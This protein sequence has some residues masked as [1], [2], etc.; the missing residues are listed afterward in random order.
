MFDG[1]LSLDRADAVPLAE[2]IYR[3]VRDAVRAGRAPGDRRLPSSR[4]LARGLGVSRNTVNAA[5]E[6]LRGEGLIVSRPGA[7]PV[8]AVPEAFSAPMAG[9]AAAVRLS[10]QG[11]ALARNRHEADYVARGG[12]LRPGH[13]DPALFPRDEWAW[14]MRRA[15]RTLS[16]DGLLY[17]HVQGLPELR[18]VLAEAL[19]ARRGLPVM[20]EQVHV[21]PTVQSALAMLG[22]CL[23]DEGET[24]WIE[25]PGY[26]GARAALGHG[27]LVPLPVDGEGADASRLTGV[28]K[29]V[30]VT[31]SHQYPTGVRMSLPRRLAL[32]A[33]AR[34]A[35]ALVLEDDY[36]SEFLW[37]G[38]QVPAL[39]ALAEQ[40]EVI[41]LGTV[42]KSLLPGL[43]LAWFVAPP[44]LSARLAHAQANLGVMANVHAQAAL[45]AFIDSGRYHRHLDHIGGVYRARG[46]EMVR[47][48]RARCGDAV[49]VAP[50]VGGL[51]VL[52]RF[53]PD[54]DDRAVAARL[55]RAGYSVPF[56]SGLYL[57]GRHSSGPNLGVPGRGILVGFAAAT[58][59][60][61]DMFAR[62]LG[63][64]LACA[65]ED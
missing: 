56:L 3:Q 49:M 31:P 9:P 63:D 32:L 26:L 10:R 11:A 34:Q 5:Y 57:S 25:E 2:Q 45:A 23:L 51:Q 21:V 16:G 27:R 50:P 60:Q 12:R 14:A 52:V 64:A 18:R 29:L 22:R 44:A 15:V 53:A 7:A 40:G 35:G 20:P 19:A 42:A 28:P 65:D 46:A 1:W 61:A 39:G 55:A 37:E 6:L 8:L 58:E 48:I 13:P 54:R 62:A 24:A 43:R 47:A 36:D 17:G 41:T 4:V 33:R 59:E 30:Y 38:R